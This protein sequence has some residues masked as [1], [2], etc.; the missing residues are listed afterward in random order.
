V[1]VAARVQELTK[2]T[3]DPLLITEATRLLLSD[4]L[5][6]IESRGAHRLRGKARE[7]TIYA[8][9]M[10]PPADS[11]ERPRPAATELPGSSSR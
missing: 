4:H 6:G 2:E 1:N 11:R 10:I 7:T 5:N 3:G 8:V 9:E